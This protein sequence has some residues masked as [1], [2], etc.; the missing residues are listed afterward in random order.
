MSIVVTGITPKRIFY[1]I[2]IKLSKCL[3]EAVDLKLFVDLTSHTLSTPNSSTSSH[4]DRGV[5]GSSLE[6]ASWPCV[7][8]QIKDGSHIVI[9]HVKERTISMKLIVD[10]GTIHGNA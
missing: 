3:Y 8:V 9:W 1:F 4:I 2:K 5:S 6:S 10:L 7:G